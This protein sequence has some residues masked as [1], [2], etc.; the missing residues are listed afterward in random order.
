VHEARRQQRLLRAVLGDDTPTVLAGQLK[1]PLTADRAI[2]VYRAN[3]G[4]LA[5]RALAAAYPTLQQ[6]M[7]EPGFAAM[8]RALWR[9]HPPSAGDV[10]RWGGELAAFIAD[11]ASLADEP[12]L[13]DV[14]RLEWALH[15]AATAADAEPAQDLALLAQH[16]PRHLHIVLMPGTALVASPYPIVAIWLAHREAAAPGA[17]AEPD[18]FSAVRAAFAEGRGETALVWRRGLA[19][20]VRAVDAAEAAFTRALLDGLPLSTALE[21]APALDFEAWLI[22]ALQASAIARVR[23]AAPPSSNLDA[24]GLAP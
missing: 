16:D 20:Q 17:T 3:A 11:S 8:A 14:A 24:R 1:G 19:P 22:A 4:A 9:R 13:A 6:L 7:G 10:A 21:A 15:E 23:C 5:T 2:T 18:R 12:Y